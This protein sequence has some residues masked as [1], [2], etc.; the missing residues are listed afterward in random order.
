MGE[1]ATMT[2]Q[3]TYWENWVRPE[4]LERLETLGFVGDLSP[5]HN[6]CPDWSHKDINCTVWVDYPLAHSNV[7]NDASEWYQYVVEHNDSQDT[8]LCTN[9]IDAVIT[10]IQKNTLKHCTLC[11]SIEAEHRSKELVESYIEDRR[12]EALFQLTDPSP[13]GTPFEE[14][15]ANC[16]T[17]LHREDAQ[18][19]L[20]HSI[21]R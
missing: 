10:Y 13:A 15:I 20:D 18:T 17:P 9:D 2:Q 5:T 7:T 14:V 12:F 6:A 3:N 4:G 16:H 11:M 8:I 1:M 19:V 21:N